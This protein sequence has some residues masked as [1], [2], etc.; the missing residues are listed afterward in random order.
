MANNE[1][2]SEY[3]NRHHKAIHLDTYRGVA[4]DLMELNNPVAD[5]FMQVSDMRG[6]VVIIQK[7]QDRAR[8][9]DDVGFVRVAKL[10]NMPRLDFWYKENGILQTKREDGTWY[11]AINDQDLAN[12]V[13]RVEGGNRK[14][15]YRFV[16]A[17]RTEVRGGLTT[18]LRREKLLN[19][20]KYNLDFLVAYHGLLLYDILLG[21][22]LVAAA[23]LS[24]HSESAVKAVGFVATAN[25]FWNGFNLSGA[26]MTRAG[27]KMFKPRRTAEPNIPDFAQDFND[28]FVKHSLAELV[29][30][31]VPVDRLAR[32]L[33]YLRKHGRDLIR[34]NL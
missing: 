25:A 27:Q 1:I 9:Y 7:P 26:E 14:F 20:G 34:T 32:G 24:G 12:Q 16:D 2:G 8:D 6:D 18:I 13:A 22:T 33:N 3:K 30:P 15:D 17:F 10:L 31:P 4:C 29:M 11:I 5:R 28:P 19:S 23:L 21:P